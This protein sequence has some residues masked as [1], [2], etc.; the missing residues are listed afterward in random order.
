MKIYKLRVTKLLCLVFVWT[1]FL[2]PQN[3]EAQKKKKKK[4]GKTEMPAK[5]APKK[6][7][8]KN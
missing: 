5:P 8:Q 4:K 7:G 6:K 1:A 3:I 2:A